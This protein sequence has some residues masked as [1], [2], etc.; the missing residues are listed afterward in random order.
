MGSAVAASK[1]G[2]AGISLHSLVQRLKATGNDFV[3]AFVTQHPD[4]MRLSPSGLN[5]VRII[6][7]LDKNDQ[8]HIIGTRLR[9]TVNSAVDNL[10]AGNIAASI[11]SNTGKVNGPA[12]T[13]ISQG[14]MS[15]NIQLR[16]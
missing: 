7:Q 9:I 14:P 13:A 3:E 15:I 4:L 6:T 8:V 2:K 10:A 5:T 12:S 1:S 16:V 11:D